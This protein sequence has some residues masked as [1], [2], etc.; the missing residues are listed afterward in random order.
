MRKTVRPLNSLRFFAALLIFLHHVGSF[1]PNDFKMLNTLFFSKFFVSVSFFFILSGFV[2][3]L[4]Y[5]PEVSKTLSFPFRKYI[6]KR[7]FSVYPL[8]IITLIFSILLTG[9]I[10]NIRILTANA[11]LLQSF[12]TD[13]EFYFSFNAMS[14]FLSDIL[15][16]YIIF[17]FLC[18]VFLKIPWKFAAKIACF[19]VIL[20]FSVI[21]YPFIY[22]HSNQLHWVFYISPFL[23]LIEFS[24]GMILGIIFQKYQGIRDR[25]KVG[26]ATFLEII[27]CLLLGFFIFYGI[28]FRNV[29][30]QSLLYLPVFSLFIFLFA[31]SKGLVSKILSS[32][33]LIYL[34][35][36]SFPFLMIH[37]LFLQSISILIPIRI[38]HSYL[39][40]LISSAFI[41]SVIFALGYNFITGRITNIL[42]P[43]KAA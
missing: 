32:G 41:F 30:N 37:W 9:G 22:R 24:T 33:I 1:F 2:L 14:W 8:H 13:P 31:L 12:H 5:F 4:R 16:L 25:L 3:A 36:L 28:T 40:S 10:I 11:L 43:P 34:G 42:S 23:R 15:F 29:Y 35:K 38:I 7:L 21:I 39:I 27:S 26:K 19:A 18:L 20:I 6:G 17:P